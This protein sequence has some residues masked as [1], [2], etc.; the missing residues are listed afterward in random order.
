MVKARASGGQRYHCSLR[1]WSCWQN[2][3]N[4]IVDTF[5]TDFQAM[6]CLQADTE[7]YVSALNTIR[8]TRRT[9]CLS[10]RHRWHLWEDVSLLTLG[11][12]LPES[13]DK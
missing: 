13:R 5:H 6:F 1:L 9:F 10:C 12:M 4:R 7:E 11:I 3:H 2:I 8:W